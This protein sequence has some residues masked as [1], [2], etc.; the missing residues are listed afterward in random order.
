MGKLP[1]IIVLIGI[2]LSSSACIG[3]YEESTPENT[4]RT[5]YEGLNERNPQK[6]LGTL[7]DEVIENA[8]GRQVILTSLE[9]TMEDLEEDEL[10]FEVEEISSETTGL[11][12]TVEAH[13][14][15]YPRGSDKVSRIPYTFS[16][17]YENE[18]W[19]IRDIE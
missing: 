16:L 9:D 7:S 18:R 19:K 1:Y 13:I 12:A 11:Q 10:I 6:V 14:K 15:L 5:Y 3:D 4:V 17:V 2:V 8:G